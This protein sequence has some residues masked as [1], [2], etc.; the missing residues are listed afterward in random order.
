MLCLHLRQQLLDPVILL[1]CGQADFDVISAEVHF[2]ANGPNSATLAFFLEEADIEGD[3][4]V[5][6]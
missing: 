6:E 5:I 3:V 4:E 1:D 2:D